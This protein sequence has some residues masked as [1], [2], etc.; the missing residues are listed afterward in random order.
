M[1]NE[2]KKLKDENSFYIKQN[3]DY[4]AEN[5]KLQKEI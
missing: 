5:D 4:E 2:L 3:Y 1:N